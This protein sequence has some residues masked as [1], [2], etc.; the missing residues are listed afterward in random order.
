MKQLRVDPPLLM[1][2]SAHSIQMQD[3][4][5]NPKPDSWSLRLLLL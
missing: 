2:G 1:P 5:H 4:L 3:P